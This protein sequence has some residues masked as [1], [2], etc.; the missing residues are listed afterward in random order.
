MKIFLVCSVC[1]SKFQEQDHLELAN[2]H[3]HLDHWKTSFTKVQV[4]DSWMKKHW[5]GVPTGKE[6]VIV[7]EQEIEPAARRMPKK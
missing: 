1:T 2:R 5:H 6:F 3:G 4:L 7:D